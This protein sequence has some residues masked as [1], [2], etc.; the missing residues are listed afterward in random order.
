MGLEINFGI[1]VYYLFFFNA[2]KED[3]HQKIKSA[4]S[5]DYKVSAITIIYLIR[6]GSNRK[7]S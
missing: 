5:I 6:A 2:P 3:E 1:K 4:F 7:N